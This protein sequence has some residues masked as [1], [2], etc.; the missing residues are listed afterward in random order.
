MRLDQAR[1]TVNLAQAFA[2]LQEGADRLTHY[3]G[4]MR[5]K[6]IKGRDYLYR[7]SGAK[8]VSLGHKI[9]DDPDW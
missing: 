4:T 5:W 2:T 6:T 8:D 7:R 9:G 3:R 1:Q